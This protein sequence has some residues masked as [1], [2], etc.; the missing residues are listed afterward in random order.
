MATLADLD[1]L[2]FKLCVEM[3][4]AHGNQ[5]SRAHRDALQDLA[6]ILGSL[7]SGNV[8]GRYVST[9][10]AGLGKT[11]SLAA[12]IKGMGHLGFGY[13]V[14]VCAERVSELI[15][16]KRE[17]TEGECPVPQD[18]IALWHAKE[19]APEP[20][21]F[22]N[23]EDFSTRQ[24]LLVTHAR[25][26]KPEV[27]QWIK[28]QGQARDLVIYDESLLTTAVWDV[29][30]APVVGQIKELTAGRENEDAAAIF[31]RKLMNAL[32][33][34]VASQ[35]RGNAPKSLRLPPHGPE[36]LQQAQ[37]LAWSR[38]EL[39]GFLQNTEADFRVIVAKGEGAKA[40]IIKPFRTVPIEELPRMIV[41]NASWPV[42]TLLKLAN[43]NVKDPSLR[44]RTVEEVW[45]RIIKPSFKR[46][47]HVE[48]N[49]MQTRRSGRQ[50]SIDDAGELGDHAIAKEVA[51]LVASIPESEGVLIWTFKRSDPRDMPDFERQLRHAIE[52]KLGSPR[53]KL[54]IETFGKETA[55]NEYKSCTNVIFAG[56]LELSPEK[57]A[58]MYVAETRDLTTPVPSDEID[59]LNRGEVWHRVLQ[60]MHR[61]SC[62]EVFV[63]DQGQTQAKPIK[64]WLFTRHHKYIKDELGAALPGAIW[65]TW[66]P[67]YMTG[68]LSK[69]A[70]GAEV[71]K[72]IL[73]K[74]SDSVTKVSLKVLKGMDPFLANMKRVTFQKARDL[75]LKD[76]ELGWKRDDRSLVRT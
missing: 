67:R 8:I 68:G 57:L 25:M 24:I 34:E 37:A 23:K 62:R 59:R 50:Y 14:L 75:A 47:N 42:R 44:L 71:I 11:T 63:D 45:P 72:D 38:K 29:L 13:S 31:L 73:A 52:E 65:R 55:T 58:G 76:D 19:E 41:M 74:L 39:S 64:V 60:G 26:Q 33:A 6:I 69:E 16:I 15:T 46:Y 27:A 12:W 61:G 2:A 40:V 35:R 51:E 21:T 7:A 3:L 36:L 32:D 56:C 28:Y 18:L 53:D 54:W 22:E 70:K 43:E 66:T 1:N 20:P 30:Y 49:V 5:L 4:E 10:G 9:L 48:M 17:L